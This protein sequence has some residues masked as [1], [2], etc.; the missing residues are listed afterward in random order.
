MDLRN[1]LAGLKQH[2]ET[3]NTYETVQ[4]SFVD[5]RLSPFLNQHLVGKPL[6]KEDLSIDA[7]FEKIRFI[8]DYDKHFNSLYFYNL[9]VDLIRQT[10]YILRVHNRM[11]A[12]IQRIDILVNSI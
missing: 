5:E 7:I 3:I 12:T 2:F 4:A 1:S 8:S 10:N 9:L 6:L 11:A